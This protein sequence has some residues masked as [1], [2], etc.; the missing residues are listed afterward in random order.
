MLEPPGEVKPETEVYWLLAARLGFPPDAVEPVIPSPS[1]DAVEGYLRRR[2]AP[3]PALTLER[4]AEGPVIAPGHQE[5]AFS[6][7]RFPTPSGK[8]ELL[9]REA[10]TRWD[11]EA[12]PDYFEPE[13]SVERSSETNGRYPLYFMTPNTK[14]RIHSQFNNLKTILALSPSPALV[15]H[16]ADARERGIAAGDRARVFNDRGELTVEAKLDSGIRRG[17]VSMTNG[18]WISQGGTVN[19]LSMGRETDMGHG[20]AFHDNLVQ[21]ER[22][23]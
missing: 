16:P 4:L 2:L 17:C 18:W 11:A 8:I 7:F 20:A 3:W 14:N 19:F 10:E 1:D 6:D 23:G 21:V 12:V 15:V 13:E 22:V 9:S 5:I